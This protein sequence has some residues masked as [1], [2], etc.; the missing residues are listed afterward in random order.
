M[1]HLAAMFPRG[2]R[3]VG[4]I[5]FAD[6]TD[7]VDFFRSY[8]DEGVLAADLM[9]TYMNME[10]VSVGRFKAELDY[11][12]I[13]GERAGEDELAMMDNPTTEE[14]IEHFGRRESIHSA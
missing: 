4:R 14:L 11:I 6:R 5:L 1:M 12:K 10:L 3:Y 2:K 13:F 8:E 9:L 7:P